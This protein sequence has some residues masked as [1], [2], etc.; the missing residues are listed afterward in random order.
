MSKGLFLRGAM[1]SAVGLLAAA[2]GSSD[3]TGG[4]GAGGDDTST[5]SNAGGAGSTTAAQTTATG[6]TTTG[7]TTA[8]STTT[9]GGECLGEQ[10]FTDAACDTCAQASCCGDIEACIEDFQ[11]G[12]TDCIN[13]DGTFNVDG[14]IANSLFTC[15]D[16]NCATECGNDG[17]GSI[18]DSGIGFNSDDPD[19]LAYAECL[20]DACCD[21]FNFCTSNGDDIQGC[22]DCLSGDQANYDLCNPANDCAV[23]NCEEGLIFVPVCDSGLG[24]GNV[25]I[26]TCLNDNCCDSFT[27]CTGDGS[28]EAIQA[29]IDCFN[30]DGGGALCDDAIA[31]EEQ[32]CST[33]IC[34][35]GL[36][37]GDVEYAACVSENCCDE[38]TACTGDGSDAA[39][40]ACIDCFNTD[41]GGALCNDAIACDEANCTVE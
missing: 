1:L 28:D 19:T 24:L 25:S 6:T 31:C 21:E 15:L 26:G 33:A 41:G 32:F 20:S 11:N 17:A 22:I 2:C 27:A 9:G 29:C 18:C 12:G 34:D 36:V 3:S 35:S 40:E 13:E 30:T 37:V 14:A 39:I 4:G 8:P 38:F 23:A 7:S 5:T 16:S 10:F